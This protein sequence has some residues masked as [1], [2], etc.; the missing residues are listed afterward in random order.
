M[1][2]RYLVQGGEM[3]YFDSYTRMVDYRDDREFEVFLLD[4]H[5]LSENKLAAVEKCVEQNWVAGLVAVLGSDR[6]QYIQPD[7][8]REGVAGA[9]LELVEKCVKEGNLD[10]LVKAKGIFV[11]R[12]MDARFK[13]AIEVGIDAIRQKKEISSQDYAA[14][15]SP[16]RQTQRK[17][18][19]SSTLLTLWGIK[20]RTKVQKVK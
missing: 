2:N 7:E 10:A 9:L 5:K 18:S 8:V 13:N 3:Y 1:C 11:F 6:F 20:P 17:H 4:A 16:V 15:T 12:N 14:K 19:L